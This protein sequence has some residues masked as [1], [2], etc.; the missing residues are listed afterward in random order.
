MKALVG[1]PSASMEDLVSMIQ[2]LFQS[3]EKS[4]ETLQVA[5]QALTES[6]E[7]NHRLLELVYESIP[8][9]RNPDLKEKIR[10]LMNE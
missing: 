9:S 3:L 6:E 8:E 10:R 4:I 1:S 2:L 5:E 7:L